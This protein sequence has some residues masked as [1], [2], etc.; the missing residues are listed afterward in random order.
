MGGSGRSGSTST[1][2]DGPPL[3]AVDLQRR[4][5]RRHGVSGGTT[6][7]PCASFVDEVEHREGDAPQHVDERRSSGRRCGRLQGRDTR[8]QQCGLDRLGVPGDRRLG[9]VEERVGLGVDGAS[10]ADPPGPVGVPAASMGAVSARCSSSVAAPGSS[11]S[12]ALGLEDTAAATDCP[13][14][15]RPR[16]PVVPDIRCGRDFGGRRGGRI[17]R[18]GRSGRLGRIGVVSVD[19]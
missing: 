2:F 15:P 12:P 19:P 5:T 11:A 9:L 10:D 6:G 4:P 7:G 17:R 13:W 8:G 18:R 1:R 3:A 14:K 16:P